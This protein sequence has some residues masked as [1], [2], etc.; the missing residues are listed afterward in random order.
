DGVNLRYDDGIHITEAGGRLIAPWLLSQIHQLGTANRART[1]VPPSTT[2]P[3][4][5]SASAAAA[6]P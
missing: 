1:P 3:A 4:G 6:T 2:P 5:V